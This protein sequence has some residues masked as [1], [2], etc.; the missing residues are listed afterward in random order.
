MLFFEWKG[1]RWVFVLHSLFFIPPFKNQSSRKAIEKTIKKKKEKDPS[2]PIEENAKTNRSVETCFFKK[3]KGF[4]L[5]GDV[6]GC[7][8]MIMLY[9]ILRSRCRH[10]NP[11]IDGRIGCCLYESGWPGLP[12]D[13]RQWM[14][15]RGDDN[16]DIMCVL[17]AFPCGCEGGW[18]SPTTVWRLEAARTRGG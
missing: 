5:L 9:S 6:V 17:Y 11:L 7:G 3:A 14:M 8:W 2:D 12:S 16:G 1:C 15:R 18:W 4:L 13:D 10:S